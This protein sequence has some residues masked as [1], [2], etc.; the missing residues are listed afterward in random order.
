ML[1]SVAL[2]MYTSLKN[3]EHYN[4][5]SGCSSIFF[6]NIPYS[7]CGVGLELWVTPRRI[8]ASA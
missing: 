5:V 8:H 2:L 6:F 3:Y 4:L 7:K 1:S